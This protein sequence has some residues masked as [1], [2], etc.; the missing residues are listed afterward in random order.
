MLHLYC[1]WSINL[2]SQI[3][4][5][6][7]QL[8]KRTSSLDLKEHLTYPTPYPFSQQP[9]WGV[10]Q[11]LQMETPLRKQRPPPQPCLFKTFHLLTRTNANLQPDLCIQTDGD[12]AKLPPPLTASLCGL[13]PTVH[14]LLW[15]LRTLLIVI[16][17]IVHILCICSYI[18]IIHNFA[19]IYAITLSHHWCWCRLR[20]FV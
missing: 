10:K 7:M 5:T 18:T 13:R 4:Q 19:V 9:E 17:N 3:H 12:D 15:I 6:V 14:I 8:P 1:I 16:H 20:S 2:N 11:P